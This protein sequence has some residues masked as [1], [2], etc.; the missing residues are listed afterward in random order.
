MIP[1]LAALVLAPPVAP[2]PGWTA[3]LVKAVAKGKKEHRLVLVDFNATWCGPCQMYRRSVFPTPTFKKAAK[4]VLLVSVDVDRQP[5][6][7]QMCGV[8]PIPDIRLIANDKAVGG[9]VGYDANALL[10]ELA[11]VRRTTKL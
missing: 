1:L 11:R 5:R 10:A 7:A 6:I 3:D 9:L 8:G 2:D 4:N